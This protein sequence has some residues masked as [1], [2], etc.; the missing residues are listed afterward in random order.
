MRAGHKLM[1]FP[2]GTSLEAEN[3]GL[4]ICT[5]L[6]CVCSHSS[7]AVL[8]VARSRLQ[9]DVQDEVPPSDVFL[10]DPFSRNSKYNL[11]ILSIILKVHTHG[12]HRG[13]VAT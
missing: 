11:D 2:E 4:I 8:T 12:S 10:S 7:V 6:S 3:T 5:S 9:H 13:S 1:E